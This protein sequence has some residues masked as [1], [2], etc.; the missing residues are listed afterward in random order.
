M[1][2]VSRRVVIVAVVAILVLAG[3][4]LARTADETTKLRA[5][6]E[7]PEFL[8]SKRG[9][10]GQPPEAAAV[11][12]EFAVVTCTVENDRRD[13]GSLVARSEGG[14]VEIA[15]AEDRV[16]SL[17]LPPGE[18]TLTWLGFEDQRALGTLTLYPGDI[19]RCHIGETWPVSGRVE[20]LDGRA[21]AGVDIIGCGG[22][23]STDENG[24]FQLAAKRGD[25]EI[26]AV[27]RDGVLQRR[28]QGFPFSP[29][30]D[31][32]DVRIQLDDEPIGGI[33]IVIATGERGVLVEQVRVDTP[34]EDAGLQDGDVL[35]AVDGKSTEGWGTEAA[36]AAITGKPGTVVQLEVL[37]A[38]EEL[39][40]AVRRER[41]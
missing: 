14:A 13:A 6:R 31:S 26:E 25:C 40:L 37:R 5:Q 34:A 10:R 24:R 17:S 39:S 1:V 28:S 38:D 4:W 2:R 36:M 3:L 33:G 15:Y 20:N 32:A 12:R 11:N 23:T 29:F 21:L 7:L 8:F 9:A 30:D 22:F 35:T 41:L 18:W 19:E 27:G 16:F